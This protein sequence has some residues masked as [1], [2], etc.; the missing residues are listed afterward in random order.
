MDPNTGQP[1]MMPPMQPGM[2][3]M[4]PGMVP[5]Q[6][7]MVPM[8]PG[9][10]P[11]Q[12]GMVPMQ[13]GMVP[14]QP[15]QPGMTPMPMQPGMM[16]V[17]T[18]T[19][20][21][22]VPIVSSVPWVNVMNRSALFDGVTMKQTTRDWW[23][24]GCCQANFEWTAHEYT[25]DYGEGDAIADKL[26][27]REDADFCGRCLSCCAPAA[28]PTR[29]D[30]W[31]GGIPEDGNRPP[32]KDRLF[33][34]EKGCT[35]G[36]HQCI[37]CDDNGR[38]IMCPCCCYL[39]YLKAHDASG[40]EMGQATYICDEKLCVPKFGIEDAS[41]NLR[42]LIRPNTCCCGCMPMFKCGGQKGR[43]MHVPFYIRTPEG[44]MVT[45][46]NPAS[47]QAEITQLWSGL[48][49]SCCEREN[50]SVNFPQQATEEDKVIIIGAT[51]L[52]DMALFEQEQ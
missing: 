7:G 5:M 29:Y 38:K 9:M 12:P 19:A 26:Y 43:C 1:M 50:Y 24:S 25:H 30:V 22:A 23:R 14:M 15:M 8:Q 16:P 45:P 37:G 21:E 41:S 34:F 18:G 33:Y 20:Q 40:K 10:V 31:A 48:A 36:T 42:Y 46:A 13:P 17:Q 47:E 4:Q 35:N 52:I 44:E 28:R 11:M 39:P 2:V 6:P 27:I 32:E 3:P 49:K 51:I